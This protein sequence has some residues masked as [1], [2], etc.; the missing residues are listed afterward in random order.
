MLLFLETASRSWPY[1]EW[2]NM[3]LIK[4]V[5]QPMKHLLVSKPQHKHREHCTL[6]HHRLPLQQY[7]KLCHYFNWPWHSRAHCPLPLTCC[8]VL[9]C[10]AAAA[11][12]A[13]EHSPASH[14]LWELQTDVLAGIDK[15]RPVKPSSAPDELH[16]EQT[17][18]LDEGDT[19]PGPSG[20]LQGDQMGLSLV[21]PGCDASAAWLEACRTPIP[22]LSPDALPQVM[23]KRRCSRQCPPKVCQACSRQTP[24][25]IGPQGDCHVGRLSCANKLAHQTQLRTGAGKGLKQ[26]PVGL[27]IWQLMRW[28]AGCRYSLLERVMALAR[29]RSLQTLAC[30]RA[31]HTRP[32]VDEGKLGSCRP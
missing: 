23:V 29:F 18:A 2:V 13:T 26:R 4:V 21:Q 3:S 28:K 5:K 10:G 17:Q 1:T 19:A 9:C 25:V 15:V 12:S 16:L 8:A 32:S 6:W 11:K 27:L 31:E 20:L 30:A 7:S 22:H 24:T 14:V